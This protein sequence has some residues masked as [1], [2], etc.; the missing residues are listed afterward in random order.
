[1]WSLDFPRARGLFETLFDTPVNSNV[2]LLLGPVKS[3]KS[4]LL[5]KTLPSHLLHLAATTSGTLAPVFLRYTPAIANTSSAQY[6]A[7]LCDAI[8]KLALLY[9]L[10]L[11]SRE[12]VVNLVQALAARLFQNNRQLVFI[13][14][15]D[16]DASGIAG[17]I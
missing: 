7:V 5:M 15:R 17:L 1:L 4:T 3:G 11:D 9:G 16:P 10:Q 6:R 14:R 8:A 13:A 12:N 2:L